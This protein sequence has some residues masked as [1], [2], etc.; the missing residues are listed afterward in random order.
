MEIFFI[1]F[2]KRDMHIVLANQNLLAFLDST[3]PDV[4]IKTIISISESGRFFHFEK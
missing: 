2:I 1:N 4:D 3:R